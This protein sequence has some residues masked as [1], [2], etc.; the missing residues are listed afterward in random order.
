MVVDEFQ[1]SKLAVQTSPTN[2]VTPAKQR[3]LITV[4]NNKQSHFNK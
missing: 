4:G 1:V 2:V 3:K